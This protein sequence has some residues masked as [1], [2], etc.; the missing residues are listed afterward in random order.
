MKKTIIALAAILIVLIAGIYFL[1]P[2]TVIIDK[3]GTV[4]NNLQ[5]V[6][7]FFS[8]S[9]NWPA[10][11]PEKRTDKKLL[12]D[13]NVYDFKYITTSSVFVDINTASINIPTSLTFIPAEKNT[14]TINWYAKT[15]SS[16]NP[17]KR[18]QVYFAAKKASRQIEALLKKISAFGSKTANLYGL[19]IKRELVKDSA[20]VSTSGSSIGFPTTQKIYLLVEQLRQYINSQKATATNAPMLNI[21]TKDSINYTVKVAIPTSRRLPSSGKIEYKWM[22]GGGNILT[23]DIKGPQKAIDSAFIIVENYIHDHQLKAPAI[24]FYSLITDR[25]A[26]KDSTKWVTRIYY[27]IMYFYD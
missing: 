22:L 19:D 21:F 16:Y 3:S 5:S 10:W 8:E 7:R 4:N 12:L 17:I 24:P 11:W 9:S 20:L 25:L 15:P 6:Y 13:G 23:A 18:L 2:N 26:E 14:V 1:I 27:P